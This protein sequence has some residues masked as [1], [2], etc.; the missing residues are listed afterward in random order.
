MIFSKRNLFAAACFSAAVL[1]GGNICAQ[2]NPVVEE[3]TRRFKL[4][5][6]PFPRPNRLRKSR[7]RENADSASRR[8]TESARRSDGK[9][10]LGTREN[11]GGTRTRF[12]KRDRELLPKQLEKMR[13]DAANA[14]RTTKLTA[15]LAEI[16]GERAKLERELALAN[17]RGNAKLRAKQ[18]RVTELESASRE[19]Q[20]ELAALNAK[21]SAPKALLA[22][23][24]NFPK[25]HSHSRNT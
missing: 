14:Q 15:K 24:R 10:F 3:K 1:F 20:M 4:R 23:N 5:K 2:E 22:K 11:R 17:G 9:T 12:R 13:L 7:A 6:R 21:F 19:L 8:R 16:D 25:S 18:L